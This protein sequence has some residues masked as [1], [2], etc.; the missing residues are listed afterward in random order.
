[1]NQSLAGWRAAADVSI[2]PISGWDQPLAGLRDKIQSSL[3]RHGFQVPMRVQGLS[4]PRFID[5]NQRCQHA[6]SR[7]PAWQ[8]GVNP[9]VEVERQFIGSIDSTMM[10]SAIR[11]A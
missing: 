9:D 8:P 7:W 1:M 2:G 11:V 10:T 3:A 4:G 5:P 6:L